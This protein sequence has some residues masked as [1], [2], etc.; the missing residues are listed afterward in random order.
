[1]KP[2][3]YPIGLIG[4]GNM[5]WQLGS[6]LSAAGFPI[7][8]VYSRTE[9]SAQYLA[10]KL[11]SPHCTSL[12]KLTDYKARLW[13]LCIAD[14]A[15]EE[16]LS[17]LKLPAD[18]LLAHTSGSQP[19]HI[20]STAHSQIGVFYPLQTMSKTKDVDFQEVPIFIEGGSEPIEKELGVLAATISQK[21]HFATSAS[22]KSLH[23]A[24]VFACN[25]T[26]HLWAITDDLLKKQGLSVN[27]LGHLIQET[28]DKALTI[29]PSEAQTGPAARRDY[30]IMDNHLKMLD[31]QPT[32]QQLYKLLSQSI[33]K[34]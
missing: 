10:S 29:P 24:A 26:N 5:A 14:S 30:N 2:S 22:R 12:G 11:H 18:S 7:A 1:M 15:F 21:V 20:L 9:A 17:V 19:L 3:Q 23:L 13:L 8:C 32:Y 28:A 4:A 34:E 27:I 25:F 6:C 31:K 16:A 33:M